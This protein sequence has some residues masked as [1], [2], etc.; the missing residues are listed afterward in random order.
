MFW[1]SSHQKVFKQNNDMIRVQFLK[2]R[3]NEA[4]LLAKQADYIL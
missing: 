3:N 1:T 2:D 4:M